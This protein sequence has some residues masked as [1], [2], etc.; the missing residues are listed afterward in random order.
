MKKNILF[1]LVFTSFIFSQT[2]IFFQI[3]KN[4]VEKADTFLIFKVEK[5]DF[6]NKLV[7]TISQDLKF[8][9]YFNIEGVKF[10]DDIEKTKKEIVTQIFI[11]GEQKQQMINIKVSDGFEK[12]IL[13]ENSYKLSGEPRF[14][15]HI[16]SDDIVEKL[17]GKPG[18]AKSKILFISDKTGKKQIYQIDYDG[19]NLKQITNLDYLVNYPRYLEKNKIVFVSYQDGWPKLAKID[20]SSGK[21]ENFIAKPG[22]NACVFPLKK[23]REIVLVLSVSGNPE[24]YLADF[25]GNI[26]KRLTDNRKIDSSPSFSPDGKLIT[27]V[28]D[29]DGKPQIY[30]MDRDGYGVRRISYISGYCTSPLFSPDGNFIAYIYSEGGVFGLAIY[31]LN[32][33][34]T[35]TIPNLN[36]EEIW[37]APNSRHIVYSKIDKK[38]SLMIIDIFTKEI[39]TLIAGEFNSSSPNWFLIE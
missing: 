18:I 17:T 2:Q 20:I 25:E 1:Y 32:T 21:I 29:R 5:N 15:G 26:K 28:S 10:T 7:E 30:I 23:T 36:C 13:Y 39:R 31:D 4:L 35:R 14:L 16:I 22:L 34:R 9:G 11:T 19:F 37:W 38:Q 12:S 27:F 8:S 24:I 6:I 3:T 33:K